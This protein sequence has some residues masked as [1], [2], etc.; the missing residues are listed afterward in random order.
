M[1]PAI[2]QFINGDL[3]LQKGMY[4]YE[5]DHQFAG[6]DQQ[7]WADLQ[8]ML[9]DPSVNA[10]LFARGG[11]GCARIIDKLDFSGSCDHQNG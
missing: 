10:V 9:D 1:Q 6:T 3:R 7:H 5:Q 11:Y 2:D 4:F 8:M